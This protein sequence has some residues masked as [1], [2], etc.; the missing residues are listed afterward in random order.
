MSS[1]LV[2]VRWSGL[3]LL[4]SL[5]LLLP[6]VAS[7]FL[8]EKGKLKYTDKDGKMGEMNMALANF[9]KPMYGA[10]MRGQLVYPATH[11]DAPSQCK[12]DQG[13]AVGCEYG[14]ADFDKAV[15]PV[16]SVGNALHGMGTREYVG[17]GGILLIDRGPQDERACKF[18]LKAWHAQLA[19]AQA[20]VIVNYENRL[21]TMDKAEDDETETYI[22]NLTIPAGFISKDD[23]DT[24]KALLT[25][26]NSG[27]YSSFS[28]LQLPVILSWEDILP[29]QEVVKWEFWTNSNDACGSS[30]DAQKAFIKSFAGV[31]KELDQQSVTQFE[32][33]YLIWVCP[34]QY[35]DS[36]QCTKQCIY[37]GRYCCPDPEDDMST[38]Y[39][40]KD[41]ILE[42]LRQLCVFSMANA[43]GKPWLWWDYTTQFGEKCKMSE[44]KYNGNCAEEVFLSL[45]GADLK[46]PDGS[47]PGGLQGLKQCIGDPTQS[48]DNMMLEH[49]KDS[50]IGDGS[51]SEVSI[52]PTVRV[53]GGQYRGSL[54]KMH[55]LRAICSSFPLNEEPEVCNDYDKTNAVDEC[56]EGAEGFMECA[57]N[58][59]S[60]KTR[61]INTFSSYYCD[62]GEG[63]TSRSSNGDSVCMDLNECLYLSMEDLGPGCTCERCACHNKKGSYSCENEIANQCETNNP[64]WSAVVEG[65]EYTA[66]VDLIQEYQ[67]LAKEG[68][69]DAS[70]PTY[71]CECPPCFTDDG[72]G[73]CE[74]VPHF[75]WCSKK[76][77]DYRL[78]MSKDGELDTSALGPSGMSIGN[79]I[80]VSVVVVLVTVL[81][82]YAVYRFQRRSHMDAEIRA[83]MAQYMPLDKETEGGDSGRPSMTG[84]GSSAPN[85]GQPLV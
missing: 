15:P 27:L 68:R 55:V 65:E 81:A 12:T 72:K 52:L 18:T 60:G 73:G 16:S 58:S 48:I 84:M 29:R 19:K 7:D 21:T 69:A 22:Q 47:G 53:N 62:C 76:S 34:P 26:G 78:P 6:S 41:V 25:K 39:D 28:D 37:D 31:A 63:W 24:L 43:T 36:E 66:C 33:H 2:E 79:I 45:G 75:D 80:I 20:V 67:D 17:T 8:V 10:T 77:G 32:P 11:A 56:E 51:V 40:G 71:K 35:K 64:C 13:E 4:A 5:A 46:G 74:A 70:T 61:C 44:N 3:L 1:G 57:A 23:G 38:G 50:Q 49:E 30:C 54:E 59:D 42:N 14:C 85:G 82:A 9:G 83:I